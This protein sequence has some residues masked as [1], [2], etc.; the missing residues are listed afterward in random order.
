MAAKRTTSPYYL[1]PPD[2]PGITLV[3]QQLA[4]D[5]YSSWYR[6]MKMALLAKDKIVFIDG[7]IP[8]PAISDE[9]YCAWQ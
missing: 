3:C 6:Y 5:N 8:C 4:G 2:S 7:S 1:H 9:N